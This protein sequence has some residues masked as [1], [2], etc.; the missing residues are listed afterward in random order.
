MTIEIWSDVMCPFCYLGSHRLKQ[1]LSQIEI[2]E[3]IEI[4][5][6]SFQLN[7][8]L[9][10]DL[11]INVYQYLSK[12]KGIAESQLKAQMQNIATA[13]KTIGLDYKFEDIVVANTFKAMQ[14]IKAADEQNLQT[15]IEE[16]LFEAYFTLGQNVDDITTLLSIATQAGMNTEN[17]SDKLNNNVYAGAVM[18]DLAEA[19][20]LNIHS[21]PF[22]IFDRKYAISGAQDSSAFVG[23]IQK[24]YEEKTGKKALIKKTHTGFTYQR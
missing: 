15:E 5:W 12:E 3:K 17:L 11:S 22:F 6:K 16:K 20:Q 18:A 13:G 8:Q 24:T 4:K 23:V 2:D 1:A 9:K 10:T 14:L 19:E 21:V 7:P